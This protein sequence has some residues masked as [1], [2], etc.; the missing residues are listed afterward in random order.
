MLRGVPRPLALLLAVAALLTVAWTFTVAPLQGPDEPAH[1]NYAQHLATTGHK[2]T[3]STGNAPDST[4]TFQAR[5]LFNLSQLAGVADARPAWSKLEERRFDDTLK[6]LG[7]DAAKDGKG[8]NALAKNPPLYYAMEAIPYYVGSI[9]SFWDR[10]T[11]MR[12]S[13]GVLFLISIVF[14]WLIASELFARTWPR[15]IAAGCFALLH[16]MTALSG[17]INAD[18]LLI[19]IWTAFLYVALRLVRHG[20]TVR[21]IFALCLL[22]GGSLLTHGRGTSILVPLLFVLVVAVVRARPGLVQA[23]RWLAPGLLTLLAIALVYQF[24]LAPS[25]GAYGGEVSTHGGSLTPAGFINTT[26]QFFLPR[27]P[28]MSESIGNGYGYRQMYIEAFFGRF[29]TLEVGYPKLVYDLIQ[30]LVFIGLCGLV[31]AIAGRWGTVRAR[32]P[33]VTTVAVTAISM[34]GLLHLASYRALVISDDPLITG[35]YLLPIGAVFGVVVAFV[36]TSLRPR[37]SALAGTFV[38]T[39]LLALNLAGLMLSFA[40]F[41]G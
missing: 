17:T 22:A 12:L 14:T 8:P 1:F 6:S 36:L 20:P 24:L 21:R 15:L 25:G 39:G 37:A 34:I 35:R 33:E 38:L 13:S 40:R 28:F 10:L 19:A 26:W 2:P 16:Q 31:A 23:A 29:A 27:L 41:Y 5:V 18:N 9:G 7:P 30:A 11:L 3:V 32:W 4:Q